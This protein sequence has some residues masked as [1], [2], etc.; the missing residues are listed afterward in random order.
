MQGLFIDKEDTIT[1]SFVLTKDSK[2]ALIAY[3]SK[4]ILE[5]EYEDVDPED[6][7]DKSCVEEY[8]VVFK[9]PSFGDTVQMGQSINM[10]DLS[11]VNFDPWTLRFQRMKHLLKSWNLK[12]NDGKPMSANAENLSKL[13]PTVANII[14]TQLDIE[15][16]SFI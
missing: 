6:F 3:D 4:K 8:T 11:S 5:E 14:G 12:D 2:G 10:S 9:R 1:I 7:Y 16:G 15:V 13:H